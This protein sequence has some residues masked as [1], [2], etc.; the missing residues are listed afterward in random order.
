MSK[1]QISSD[2]LK[3][4]ILSTTSNKDP[5]LLSSILAQ[6]NISIPA[7]FNSLFQE[8]TKKIN[9]ISTNENKIDI[10]YLNLVIDHFGNLSSLVDSP[11]T[12]IPFTKVEPIITKLLQLSEVYVLGL[13]DKEKNQIDPATINLILSTI[14]KILTNILSCY[15]KETIDFFVRKNNPEIND[16]L[17]S[18]LSN[19]YQIRKFIYTFFEA[20]K[21]NIKDPEI[22]KYRFR[23]NTLISN[24][25][26][27]FKPETFAL[28]FT[29]V[30]TIATI[31]ENDFGVIAKEYSNLILFVLHNSLGLSKDSIIGLFTILFNIVFNGSQKRNVAISNF[32]FEIYQKEINS[33]GNTCESIINSLKTLLNNDRYEWM[34]TSTNFI[35]KFINTFP[36]QKEENVINT[37]F[38]ILFNFCDSKKGLSYLPKDEL[39][40]IISHFSEYNSSNSKNLTTIINNIKTLI[41]KNIEIINIILNYCDYF[42]YSITI[43]ENKKSEDSEI[44]NALLSFTEFILNTN[45]NKYD[46]KLP[47]QIKNFENETSLKSNSIS[48]EYEKDP[49]TYDEKLKQIVQWMLCLLNNK[50]QYNDI[51]NIGKIIFQSFNTKNFTMLNQ[52][53]KYTITSIIQ[54]FLLLGD[55]IG[56]NNCEGIVGNYLEMIFDFIKKSNLGVIKYKLKKDINKES[57]TQVILICDNIEKMLQ[58]F[59]FCKNENINITAKEYLQRHFYDLNKVIIKSP[60]V[61]LRVIS[62]YM[63]DQKYESKLYKSLELLL[64]FIKLNQINAK[65]ILM[66]EIV[67]TIM[68][69]IITKR[70]EEENQVVN[71]CMEILRHLIKFFT[72][73]HL[74]SLL[75]NVFVLM[76]KSKTLNLVIK[77]FQIIRESLEVINENEKNYQ[78]IYLS[79][80]SFDNP[81]IYNMLM[82]DSLFISKENK[83]LSFSLSIVFQSIEE[84]FL[85]N[86]CFFNL[87]APNYNLKIFFQNNKLIIREND[88]EE[89]FFDNILS[90]ITLNENCVFSVEIEKEKQEITVLINNKPLTEQPF[91]LEKF[92]VEFFSISIGYSKEDLINE[93]KQLNFIE[94]SEFYCFNDNISVK[95]K[96]SQ[97]ITKFNFDKI[98]VIH[99]KNIEKIYPILNGLGYKNNENKYNS[100]VKFNNINNLTNKNSNCYLISDEDNLSNFISVNGIFQ[101]ENI[102]RETIQNFL[103]ISYGIDK[104]VKNTFFIEDIFKFL[105]IEKINTNEDCFIEIIKIMVES[106]TIKKDD[107][108]LKQNLEEIKIILQK[109]LENFEKNLFF[110]KFFEIFKKNENFIGYILSEVLLDEILFDKLSEKSQKFVIFETKNSFIN[111]QTEGKLPYKVSEQIIDKLSN[112]LC[113]FEMKNEEIVDNMVNNVLI[114]YDYLFKLEAKEE[115]EKYEKQAKFYLN[116]INTYDEVV[117]NH[118]K[119]GKKEQINEEDAKE[120]FFL[121]QK[122]KSQIDNLSQHLYRLLIKINPN[123]FQNETSKNKTKTKDSSCEF[124]SF[125]HTHFKLYFTNLQETQLLHKKTVDYLTK[126]YLSNKEIQNLYYNNEFTFYLSSKETNSRQRKKFILKLSD[127]EKNPNV[128]NNFRYIY[129]KKYFEETF[130]HLRKMFRL[131]DFLEKKLIDIICD[132]EIPFESSNCLYIKK[133]QKTQCVA[134]VTQFCLYVF[135]NVAIDKKNSLHV[136][137]GEVSD[138]FWA[139]SDYQEEWDDFFN[140]EKKDKFIKKETAYEYKNNKFSIKRILFRDISEIY[141]RVYLHIENGIEIIM[142]NGS[143]YYFVFNKDK[144]DGIFSRIITNICAIYEEKN[145]V[146][147]YNILKNDKENTCFYMRHSPFNGG[148]INNKQKG[149][150]TK[151]VIVKSLVDIKEI[152]NGVS[153]QWSKKEINNFDYIMFLNTLSGRTYNNLSQYFVF[154]WI[155]KDFFQELKVSSTKMY[156]D[157]NYPIFAQDEERRE[158]VK[159]K[160]EMKDEDNKYHCGTF[161]STHAFVSYYMIRQCPYSEIALEIQGGHFDASDRLFHSLSQLSSMDERFQELIPELF[162]LPELY[163]NTNSYVFGRTQKRQIVNDVELPPWSQHDPRMFV[164]IHRKILEHKKVSESLNLWIDMIFGF[165]QSGK[166]AVEVYN[167]YRRACYPFGNKELSKMDNCELDGVLYEAAELGVNPT[168]LFTKPHVSRENCTWFSKNNYFFDSREKLPNIKIEKIEGVT[169]SIQ[170]G[171]I[172]DVKCYSE[173]KFI[174]NNLGGTSSLYSL[175]KANNKKFN[176]KSSH[177]LYKYFVIV[178]KGKKILGTKYKMYISF[179]DNVLTIVKP[180]YNLIYE[181]SLSDENS[182]ITSVISNGKG[183]KIVV[184]F[185][186]G[187]IVEYKLKIKSN[188]YIIKEESNVVVTGMSDKKQKK[189]KIIQT[190]PKSKNQEQEIDPKISFSHFNN[191]EYILF[192]TK[193]KVNS[194]QS[195]NQNDQSNNT[196]SSSDKYKDK[197]SGTRKHKYY[198]LSPTGHKSTIQSYSIIFLTL[199]E[200]NSL[201]IASDSKNKIYLYNYYSFSLLNTIDFLLQNPYPLKDILPIKSTGD[202][203]VSTF[204][205]VTLFSLNGVP[206][207]EVNLTDKV[208]LSLSPITSTEVTCLADVTLFTG[209]KNGNL[210]IWKVK[211]KD[212]NTK[213]DQRSSFQYNQLSTKSFLDEYKY[214]YKR[215]RIDNLEEYELKRKFDIIIT[216]NMSEIATSPL[217]Y[218]KLSFD[219]TDMVIFDKEQKVYMLTGNLKDNLLNQEFPKKTNEEDI[220]IFNFDNE[221]ICKCCGKEINEC[222][223]ERESMFN[224]NTRERGQEEEKE[225]EKIT[226]KETDE[227]LCEECSQVLNNSDYFLYGY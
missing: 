219:M 87:L 74:M 71:I 27:T 139:R 96:P 107:Q 134:V 49:S 192:N 210:I 214:A 2:K 152:V 112:L 206:L 177:P 79:N 122:I 129:S 5:S 104:L 186:N 227:N 218:M 77:L 47:M 59:L 39:S 52:V 170:S 105:Y 155:I 133:M 15:K 221:K 199:N 217:I 110:E 205:S 150:I 169:C 63:K 173:R 120:I 116:L 174:N 156:R 98:S 55:F 159:Y 22:S 66:F 84:T 113:H 160:Y 46:Y 73:S 114:L 28:S 54:I 85:K 58:S 86:F 94:I 67:E 18:S 211:N 106:A 48:L 53:E 102:H 90:K 57:R 149:G 17:F 12:I 103:F 51:I 191:N 141:K 176:S 100:Y 167:T 188:T 42:K 20:L 146:H 88:H 44:K 226:N 202:F 83:Y 33:I 138:T 26:A 40:N 13:F 124:C 127:T 19:N 97:L 180:K 34:V 193:V 45:N 3:K 6:N 70:D 137:E 212:A 142:R 135:T 153:V 37:Y 1:D 166:D 95:P 222:Y 60:Y 123:L 126:L 8:L 225:K 216:M 78:N 23:M 36:I 182:D 24:L 118:M 119:I 204:L 151:K 158:T 165:R 213:Y 62:I 148:P 189:E 91:K 136:A 65:C 4:L 175:M 178:N 29:E 179:H 128:K 68:K 92:N 111:L 125:I 207:A 115:K 93:N 61:L 101:L 190:R 171:Q 163:V 56:N 50:D 196:S 132:E 144:R 197:S 109:N 81:F 145:R 72:K 140:P 154:P 209:H 9:Y 117:L 108:L 164:L 223:E 203:I 161:Y 187:N 130:N 183:N 200:P 181:F 157:L 16:T 195:Q 184:G 172:G 194:D 32:I 10:D 162:Y 208:Y 64:N 198:Y 31:Y 121:N 14:Q 43:I 69:I 224:D 21:E 220:D 185:E 82:S 38:E 41:E 89:V 99:S 201:L 11:D 76:K 143:S 35:E 7:F 25:K 131:D 215:N 30:K 168:Q 147:N 80:T 75:T